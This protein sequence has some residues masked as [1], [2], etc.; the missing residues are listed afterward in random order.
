MYA[1][2]F[3]LRLFV[4]KEVAEGAGEGEQEVAPVSS[5]SLIAAGKP[6]EVRRG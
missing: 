4:K 1:V 6:K 5:T 3:F 2:S